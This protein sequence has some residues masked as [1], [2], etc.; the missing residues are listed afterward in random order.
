MLKIMAFSYWIWSV[1]KS[2]VY[3]ERCES[4]TIDFERWQSWFEIVVISL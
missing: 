4:E 2:R 1:L 3:V